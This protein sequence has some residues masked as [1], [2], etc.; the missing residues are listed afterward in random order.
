MTGNLYGWLTGNDPNAPEVRTAFWDLTA[1]KERVNLHRFGMGTRVNITITLPEK[2]AQAML[3]EI[4]GFTSKRWL[5][6][7]GLLY[8]QPVGMVRPYIGTKWP[9]GGYGYD[10]DGDQNIHGVEFAAWF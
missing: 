8:Y 5:Q 10:H 1:A 2:D 6:G 9:P 3:D 7:L 4:T